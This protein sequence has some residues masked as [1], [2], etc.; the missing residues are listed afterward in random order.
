MQA[1]Q[2]DVPLPPG[3]VPVPS[4]TRPGVV[5]YY[6]V[7]SRATRWEPPSPD[8]ADPAQVRARHILVKHSEVRNPVSKG[9]KPGPVT[10]SREEAQ[11]IA[12]EL[13]RD[14]QKAPDRFEL[15]AKAESDCNSFARGGD[16][17]KPFKHGDM[18]KEFSDAAFALDVGE[19]SGVVS[20]PSGLH[21]IQRVE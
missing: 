3:W 7:H 16:L 15:V 4:K 21:I 12:E 2:E 1:A 18:H 14:V 17:G 20:S 5:Y 19:I 8:R 11:R 6:N 13:L 10:R 9:A